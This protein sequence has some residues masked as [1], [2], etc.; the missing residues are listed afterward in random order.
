MEKESAAVVLYT[1]KCTAPIK[2]IIHLVQAG[3]VK[4]ASSKLATLRGDGDKIV[5]SIEGLIAQQESLECSLIQ[6]EEDIMRKIGV[7]AREEQELK[8]KLVTKRF[9]LDTKKTALQQANTKL[10]VARR[11]YDEARKKKAEAEREEERDV[12]TG[13]I[14]GAVVGLLLGPIGALVGAGLGAGVGKI[15]AEL[16]EAVDRANAAVQRRSTDVNNAGKSISD[17]Q[18]QVQSIED[19][20]G[21]QER[22]LAALHEERKICHDEVTKIKEEIVFLKQAMEFW[23]LLKLRAEESVDATKLVTTLMIKA[24]EKP[25]LLFGRGTK[26]VAQTFIDAWDAVL[27]ETETGYSNLLR[28]KNN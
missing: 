21:I 17:F 3:K 2:E 13:A 1:K 14:T 20:I 16:N 19:Q 10:E 22:V 23:S 12:R 11:E 18:Q 28:L 26:I 4:E 27:S 8:N 7:R 9:E 24:S 6:K 25:K 15:V 5:T